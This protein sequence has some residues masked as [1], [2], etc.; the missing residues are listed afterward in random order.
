MSE[1]QIVAE[2]CD[3]NRHE[4]GAAVSFGAAEW[5]S[6][7]AAPVF[8][9]MALLTAVDGG[10]ATVALC[11]GGHGASPLGGMLPMY[12]LMSAFHFSP[13]VR[14]ITKRQMQPRRRSERSEII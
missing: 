8:A 11:S 10:S 6:F 4:G 3:S 12:V 14:L 5:L 13:W 7:G 2:R 1:A 9:I